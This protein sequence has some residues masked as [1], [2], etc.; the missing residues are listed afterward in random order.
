MSLLARDPLAMLDAALDRQRDSLLSGAFESL[1]EIEATIQAAMA[2]LRDLPMGRAHLQRLSA[3][4]AKA[5]HQGRLLQAALQGVQDARG[6]RQTGRAFTSYDRAGR[7]GQ[8]GTPRPR[9]E[10][11]S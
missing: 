1:S 10:R 2:L 5:A 8:I 11:R 7:A 6:A 9:F 3:I 4:R